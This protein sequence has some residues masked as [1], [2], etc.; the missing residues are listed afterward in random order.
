MNEE[1]ETRLSEHLTRSC[2]RFNQPSDETADINALILHGS[3]DSEAAAR[4]LV[5]SLR[6]RLRDQLKLPAKVCPLVALRGVPVADQLGEVARAAGLVLCV[7]RDDD[8]LP[9]GLFRLFHYFDQ[10]LLP[11]G[12]CFAFL[13]LVSSRGGIGSEMNRTFMQDMAAN[14]GMEFISDTIL[15]TNG[16][17]SVT[18]EAAARRR[19]AT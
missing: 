13:Q 6:I 10:S 7:V 15:K 19:F 9:P 11:G 16:N 4:R 18:E 1:L 17:R 3:G 12:R 8:E 5:E 14:E 2:V